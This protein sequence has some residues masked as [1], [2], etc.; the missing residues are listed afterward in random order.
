MTLCNSRQ[1]NLGATRS[2]EQSDKT[3]CERQIISLTLKPWNVSNSRKKYVPIIE[4]E[5]KIPFLVV[6]CGLMD[7][8][9]WI[10]AKVERRSYLLKNPKKLLI[11]GTPKDAS[12]IPI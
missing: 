9:I 4:G 3:T 6:I 7:F 8:Y 12:T 1:A 5:T 11:L 2:K 10:K